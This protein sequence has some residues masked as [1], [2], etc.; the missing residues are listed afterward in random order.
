MRG[1][2][3]NAAILPLFLRRVQDKYARAQILT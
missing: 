3:K 2:T 1:Q